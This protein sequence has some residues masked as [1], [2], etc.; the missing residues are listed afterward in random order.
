MRYVLTVVCTMIVGFS[1]GFSAVTAAGH[2]ERRGANYAWDPTAYYD[3]ASVGWAEDM[4]LHFAVDGME[5]R[6][7]RMKKYFVHLRE[8]VMSDCRALRLAADMF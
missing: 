8:I 1:I 6:D 3:M 5:D 7:E 4:R 2:H